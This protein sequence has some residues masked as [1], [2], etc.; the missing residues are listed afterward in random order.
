MLSALVLLVLIAVTLLA[1][2]NL[3]LAIFAV[4]G[5]ALGWVVRNIPRLIRAFAVRAAGMRR[6]AVPKSRARHLGVLAVAVGLLAASLLA[7]FYL[8]SAGDRGGAG[9]PVFVPVLYS[10][11]A[12][13]ETEREAF[14]LHERLVVPHESLTLYGRLARQRRVTSPRKIARILFRQLARTGWGEPRF[15]GDALELSRESES[16]AADFG[17]F[18]KRA[19]L[20]LPI[21]DDLVDADLVATE[22]TL[23]VV[24]PKRWVL[25]TAP[26]SESETLP[27]GLERRRLEPDKALDEGVEVEL[28]GSLFR[29]ELGAL[30]LGL[31]VAGTVKWGVLLVFGVLGRDLEKLVAGI[32]GRLGRRRGGSPSTPGPPPPAQA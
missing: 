32:V 24:A 21:P 13:L 8:P 15:L 14:T 6:V 23:D 31:S 5:F 4:A 19:T 29:N 11:R 10:A 16:E 18:T 22:A 17:P 12:T 2:L 26:P 20:T 9:A 1:A 25:A 3:W 7:V 27:G 28:A 30:L